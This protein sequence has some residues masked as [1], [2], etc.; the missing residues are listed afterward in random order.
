MA[1]LLSIG[2]TILKGIFTGLV[3]VPVGFFI[4]NMLHYRFTNR[5][6][7]K[8]IVLDYLEFVNMNYDTSERGRSRY[9]LEEGNKLVEDENTPV[10][11]SLPAI[12]KWVYHNNTIQ[13]GVKFGVKYD[14]S[15]FASILGELMMEGRVTAIHNKDTDEIVAYKFNSFDF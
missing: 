4:Y 10:Y 1:I 6:E 2:I 14:E 9:I 7:I 11:P 15:F 13:K 5:D 3:A 12:M 8:Q